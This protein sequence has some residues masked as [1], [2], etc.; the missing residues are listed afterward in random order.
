MLAKP[1]TAFARAGHRLLMAALRPPHEGAVL[2]CVRCGAYSWRRR[3]NLPRSCSG[4]LGAASAAHLRRFLQGL[5]PHNSHNADVRLGPAWTPTPSALVWLDEGAGA[6]RPPAL[7]AGS[8]A[9][10]F[11]MGASSARQYIACRS[12]A[13]DA[14]EHID[15][16]DDGDTA[17]AAV[18]IMPVQP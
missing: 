2:M 12:G 18:A 15:L 11:E 6:Y 1:A 7:A 14:P 10:R 3:R 13:G 9:Q 5:F 8:L 4:Q 17:G 16:A